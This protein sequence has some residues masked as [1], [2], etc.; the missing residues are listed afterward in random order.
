MQ[1]SSACPG[2]ARYFAGKIR[3]QPGK[4]GLAE[5]FI[6]GVI[7]QL[8]LQHDVAAACGMGSPDQC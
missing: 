2:T 7:A 3:E 8:I 1:C 6:E 5:Y 4:L